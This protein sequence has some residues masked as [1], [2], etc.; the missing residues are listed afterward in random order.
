MFEKYYKILE[1]QNN[2]T[3]EEIKKSYKKLA[4]KWHP[5]KNLDNKEAAE[6]KFKE[7]S[8]AYEVL[9]NKD[10]Y[11]GQEM[12]G[13]CS[14][15][16]PHDI[17]NQIFKDMHMQTNNVHTSHININDILSQSMGNIRVSTSTTSV[18]FEGDKKIEKIEQVI[19]GVKKTTINVSHVNRDRQR[20]IEEFLFR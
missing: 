1:L 3:D 11:K 10:K 6:K 19:N 12:F 7:I 2:A 14:N 17:F 15:I 4:I 9:T 13:N 5:D 16:N 18:R 8:E 20:G